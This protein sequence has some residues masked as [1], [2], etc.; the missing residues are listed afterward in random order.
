MKRENTNPLD[1]QGLLGGQTDSQPGLLEQAGQSI[2]RY[3]LLEK[4]GE[5]GFGVVYS[6][7]QRTPV[8]RR[9]ALKIIKPGMDSKQVIGRFEA[10]RQAL[11]MMDHPNIAKV[12]DA[13]ATESGRPYFVMELVKGISITPY[14]DQEK[15]STRQRLDLFIPICHAIQ[16]AH[17]KG[18]IHR[19][20][21]PSNILVALHDGVPVPKVIDFGIAKATQQDLTDKTVYT[22]F[23]QFIGTPAYMSPEQAEMSGLDIDTRSD[24]YSLGV[25]LYELLTGYTPFDPDALKKAG[26]DAMRKVIREQAPQRPSTKLVTLQAE[27]LSTTA[28]RRAT[29]APKL[30]SQL[31]GDLDWIVLKCLEK[32]R[33]RRYETASGLAMDL[34]RHHHNEPVVARPPSTVYRL[35]KTVQRN[36]LAFAAAG[37][38]MVALVIGFVMSTWGAIAATRARDVADSAREEAVQATQNER[39]LNF[40]MAFDRGLTLCDQGQVGSGL[41]WLTRSL[42]LAPADQAAMKR[43]LRANL[44]AWRRELHTLEGIFLHEQSVVGAAFSP[45]GKMI[46]SGSSD[47]VAQRWDRQ[48]GV[49]IWNPLRHEAE[50][51]EV[52]FSPD[53]ARF[54]TASLDGTAR[55]WETQSGQHIRT[56]RHEHQ[57]LGV[58]F[59]PEGR[60]VTSTGKG[61]IKIWDAEQAEPVG[62]LLYE[63]PSGPAMMHDLA[64]SPDGKHLLAACHDGVVL[65]WD[66][67]THEI[68]ARFPHDGTRVPTA[69]FVG[70]EGTRIATGDSDGNVVFWEWPDGETTVEGYPVGETWRHGGGVH[71]LRASPDGTRILTASF[72]THAQFLNSETGRPLGVPI[73]HQSAVQGVVFGPD[74]SA[75]TGCDDN[76]AR[77]WRP[78]SGSLLREHQFTSRSTNETLF[79]ADGRYCLTRAATGTASVFSTKTGVLLGL[80]FQPSA[81]IY[82]FTVTPDKMKIMTGGARGRVQL[83][84]ATTGRPFG[85]AYDHDASV[86]AV[87]VSHDGLHM[88]SAGMDGV[89]KLW[90]AQL[91]AP[92]RTVI[93]LPGVSIQAVAF[94]PQ[95]SSLAIIGGGDKRARLVNVLTGKV[96]HSL[97]GHEGRVMVVEFSPDGRRVLTGSF[98]NTVRIWD[99]ETGRR[100]SQP[101]RHQGPL[102]YYSAFSPDGSAI[103]TGCDDGTARLWD[104][105][106]AKPIGPK[107]KH[108]AALRTAAF[109]A[110]GSEIVTGTAAGTTRFWDVSSSPIEGDL[111]RIKVWLQVVTGMELESE[112]GEIRVLDTQTWQRRRAL[113]RELGGPPRS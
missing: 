21:K 86:W 61:R 73:E 33:S 98:D 15:L 47:G 71:R 7:Q 40:R 52:V 111:E 38:V 62:E 54:V 43:A 83:W 49:P 95:D 53:G 63:P 3:K 112:S 27:E 19:D 22:H 8:T 44:S 72:D 70:Q 35:Q 84:D 41:L 31:R 90:D 104:V 39:R 75:L 12:L 29:E 105:A 37:A 93:I 18:I 24:I 106:T 67:A 68:I 77:L 94:N 69:D 28:A 1:A 110:G 4:L 14:C 80:P 46:V 26:L 101:M 16:H 48:T 109:W 108:Q 65:L 10:E 34:M 30:I 92:L 20:L 79:T 113:L 59:T 58:V 32:D 76:A 107:L 96:S 81:G 36:K 55:L 103:V 25:L 60:I 56:F 78:A 100:V 51:H 45:D 23:Q 64:L 88:L 2:G 82:A 91:G 6:A 89:V 9:V 17:Q 99:V 11:A 85:Q 5:G 87:A 13:G 50:V 42:E 74:G 97:V 102:W 66:L 57:V